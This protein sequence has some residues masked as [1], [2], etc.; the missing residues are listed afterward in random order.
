MPYFSASDDANHIGKI[1]ENPKLGGAEW[2][3]MAEVDSVYKKVPGQIRSPAK[4]VKVLQ[5][6]G[7]GSP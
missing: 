2:L 6:I 3:A 7:Y 1:Y 5:A 4:I